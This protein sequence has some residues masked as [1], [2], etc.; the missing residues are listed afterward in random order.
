M[1]V[2]PLVA[3]AAVA[4]RAFALFSSP[5]VPAP[6]PPF[7]SENYF[8]DGLM[9][10]DVMYGH[11]ARELEDFMGSARGGMPPPMER[12][13]VYYPPV[14]V[15]DAEIVGEERSPVEAHSTSTNGTKP[16][17]LP[18]TNHPHILLGISLDATFDDVRRAYKRLVK[19]YHPDAAVGPDASEE[20]RQSANRDF[21]RIN[22]A[23]DILKRRENEE[24]FEYT[25]YEDGQR[26]TRSVVDSEESRRRDPHRIDYDRIRYGNCQ[27][28]ERM[29]YENEHSYQPQCNGFDV[30]ASSYSSPYTRGRWWS[31]HNYEPLKSDQSRSERHAGH[32]GNSVGF[33][34]A[35]RRDPWWNEDPSFY[36]S[37][38]SREEYPPRDGHGAEAERMEGFAYKDRVW[39]ERLVS[40]DYGPR[41]TIPG[42]PAP[43]YEYEP[44]DFF[45]PAEKWWKADGDDSWS[46]FAP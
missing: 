45:P 34:G 31:Q 3:A 26:V 22:A 44:E 2:N 12:D 39:G 24:V 23:Y 43:A 29:W 30:D 13:P 5:Q 33:G 28:R 11:Q 17:Q 21:A 46:N 41:H 10:Q 1:I 9:D 20:E 4:A 19:L 18:D 32:E 37:H 27:P 40:D 15:K 42:P 8:D 35:P 6:P 14:D 25:A 38:H 7:P 36:G 16:P